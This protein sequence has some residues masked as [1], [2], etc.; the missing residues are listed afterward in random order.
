MLDRLLHFPDS[1][2]AQRGELIISSTDRASD[3]CNPQ[4]HLTAPSPEA[5]RFPGN[6]VPALWFAGLGDH[7]WSP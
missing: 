6:R 4:P 1:Q 3:L 5:S 7:S 2:G